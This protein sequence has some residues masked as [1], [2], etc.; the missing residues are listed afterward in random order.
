VKNL[1][2]LL[3]MLVASSS[4]AHEALP[5]VLSV[6]ECTISTIVDSE[7]KKFNFVVSKTNTFAELSIVRVSMNV[8]S[9]A[10][11]A[12]DSIT[13]RIFEKGA[14]NNTIHVLPLDAT[15]VYV[16]FFTGTV[17]AFLSC[18]TISSPN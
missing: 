12:E 2:I 6:M 9:T 4:Y 13:V 17:G 5:E 15:K 14:G 7:S 10:G 18:R 8:T 16:E 3:S 11:E 1:F